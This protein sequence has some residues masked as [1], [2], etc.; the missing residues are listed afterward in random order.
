MARISTK[1]IRNR[2]LRETGL[3]SI[4]HL[5]TAKMFQLEHRWGLSILE[6]L[7]PRLGTGYKLARKYALDE[8]TIWRWRKLFYI[9]TDTGAKVA[10]VSA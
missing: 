5:K 4:E 1:R 3:D 10:R 9:P 6:L 2:V 7:D 8:A